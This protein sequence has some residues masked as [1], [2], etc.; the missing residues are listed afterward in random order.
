VKAILSLAEVRE[1]VARAAESVGGV[2]WPNGLGYTLLDEE[3]EPEVETF[4]GNLEF[5]KG[6][7]TWT[8]TE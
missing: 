8:V 1:R 5:G 6:W 7:I 4:G 2:V 3:G